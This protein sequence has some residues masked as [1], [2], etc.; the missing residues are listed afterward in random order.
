MQ[1]R[2]YQ[3]RLIFGD[4]HLR[5]LMHVSGLGEPVPAYLPADLATQ[6][7][8]YARFGARIVAE[9]HHRQDQ[10]ERSALAL[11]VLALA[12]VLDA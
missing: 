9:L 1:R 2:K 11:R 12:R 7:P 6:L 3:K 4:E 10:Y 8:L 5:T